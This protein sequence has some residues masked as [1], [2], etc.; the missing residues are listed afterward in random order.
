MI[1][2]NNIIFIFAIAAFRISQSKKD[3]NHRPFCKLANSIIS[4]PLK[5]DLFQGVRG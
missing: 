2:D 4:K 5:D 1:W 3:G